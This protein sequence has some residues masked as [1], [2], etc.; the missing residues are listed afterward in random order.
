MYMEVLWRWQDYL[1][2]FAK[3][4]WSALFIYMLKLHMNHKQTPE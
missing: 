4:G 2:Y 3:V 1:K